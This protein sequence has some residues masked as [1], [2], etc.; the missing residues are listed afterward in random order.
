M[1][2]D[3]SSCF[4]ISGK[5]APNNDGTYALRNRVFQVKRELGKKGG[6]KGEGRKREERNEVRKKGRS[7]EGRKKKRMR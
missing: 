5:E 3:L 1:T 6:R 2:F 7:K 4:R